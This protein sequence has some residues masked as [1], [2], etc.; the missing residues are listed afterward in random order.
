M[1]F[2][3]ANKLI[4]KKLENNQNMFAHKYWYLSIHKQGH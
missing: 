3:C 1:Y 2:N 4:K